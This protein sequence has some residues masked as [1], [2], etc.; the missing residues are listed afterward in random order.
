[1]IKTSS[2]PFS[3]WMPIAMA[4]MLIAGCKG[5]AP[6]LSQ[7][8]EACMTTSDCAS[9]LA[10]KPTSNGG[11]VCVTSGFSI[12]TTA[13]ECVMTC[14]TKADCSYGMSCTGGK[15]VECSDDSECG[16]SQM[17]KRGLC[18]PEQVTKSCVADSECPDYQR[19]SQ[20]ACVDSGCQTDRECV[21]ST[22]HVDAKCGGDAK[23]IVPC[24]TDLECGDPTSYRFNS[25]VNGQCTYVGCSDDKECEFY[26]KSNG[27]SG[28]SG[29]HPAC[30]DKTK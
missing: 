6:R 13:K 22:G 21:A 1:M 29:G 23:C 17:C 10:C 8:G 30:V 7:R 19:C 14:D 26:L 24:Q 27:S 2:W 12:S 20:G 25:C 3:L 16:T 11:G 28:S 9:S 5:D 15:C 4:S 18:V